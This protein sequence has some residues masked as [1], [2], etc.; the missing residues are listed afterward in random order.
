MSQTNDAAPLEE[1]TPVGETAEETAEETAGRTPAGE[2]PEAPEDEADGCQKELEAAKAELAAEKDKYLRLLAE[3]DNFRKRSARERDNL[4]ADVR[5]DTITRLLPVYD[6]LE[7]ALNT[8]T[9]D[10]AYR[11]G[12]EM[13]MNQFLEALKGMGVTPIEAEGQ[14]FDPELHHAVMHLE[15]P[16]R[17]EQEIVQ[18]FQKGFRLGDKPIRFSM[19][20]VAN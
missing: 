10:E 2:T 16:E 8:P 12:V 17:G 20:Q 19:V 15:D 1:E 9:A 7:R 13:T 5:A 14:T 6:N 4:Y 3:Y 11:K 18:E